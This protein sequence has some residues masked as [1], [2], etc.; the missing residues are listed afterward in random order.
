MRDEDSNL[1]PVI[2]DR[3]LH[4]AFGQ[5]L[6]DDRSQGS[7]LPLAGDGRY[8]VGYLAETLAERGH[9]LPPVT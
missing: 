9:G 6:P 8:A 7:T 2:P 3:A 1:H 4:L 5:H